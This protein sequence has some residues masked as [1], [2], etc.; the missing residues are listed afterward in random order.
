MVWTVNEPVQMVEVR[1]RMRTLVWSLTKVA[2]S[3]I[4][5]EMGRGCDHH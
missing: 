3:L 4:G 5:C 2:G 1:M